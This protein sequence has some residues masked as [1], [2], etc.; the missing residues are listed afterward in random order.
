[1]VSRILNLSL[2]KPDVFDALR[3]ADELEKAAAEKNNN[4]AD[5]N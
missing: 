4:P 2:V 3:A 1:M 5:G